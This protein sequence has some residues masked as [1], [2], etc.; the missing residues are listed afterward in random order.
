MKKAY[1]QMHLAILLWG[2]TAIFGKLIQLDEGLLVWYRMLISSLSMLVYLLFTG[3]LKFNSYK[4]L[5][6]V[7][8]IGA[9]ITL[10]WIT[11]YGAIKASN[12]S[13]AISCFSSVAL[14]TALLDPLLGKKLPR[15]NEIVT[16]LFVIAGIYLIFRVQELYLK[17]I[18][19][20][21]ISALLAALFTILNK[22]ISLKYE[23]ALLTFLELGTGFLILTMLLPA[24]FM[25]N[26]SAFALPSQSDF[27]YLLL[28]SILCTTFAFTLSLFALKKLD[29]FTMSLSVNLEPLYSII[30]AIIIFQENESLNGWF[31]AGSLLIFSTVMIHG[32]IAYRN[33][34]RLEN[35]NE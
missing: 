26:D 23:P 29:S 17:G 28:L 14:F 25:V 20:S 19:L 2:F 7:A 3:K 13:V 4:E 15:K 10:H 9:I 30:L 5:A 8:G 1:L 27:I 33:R 24:W 35:L 21:L 11:F 18:V 22:R 16:A 6:G 12:V 31:Y 34:K 32:F